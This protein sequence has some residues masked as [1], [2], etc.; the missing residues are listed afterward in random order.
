MSVGDTCEWIFSRFPPQELDTCASAEIQT[1][2]KKLR[3]ELKGLRAKVQEAEK[4][5][6]LTDVLQDSHR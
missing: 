6:G 4:A 3:K 5:K 1:E 2:V